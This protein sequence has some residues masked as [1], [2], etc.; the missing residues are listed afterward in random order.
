MIG[1]LRDRVLER[2]G[3]A[4]PPNPDLPGLRSVYAAW[5]ERVPFDN[6]RK[7]IALLTGGDSPLPGGD[8]SDFFA[9][10]LS[11]GCGGTCW[12][13]SNALFE[14]LDSLGFRARRV[15]GSM[16]DLGSV[17]HA[18]VKVSLEGRDWLVDSS[19]LTNIP[20]PLACGVFVSDDPV[21][22]AEVE[23]D[24]GTHVIWIQALS[25]QSYLPCRLLV[26]PADH[27]FYSSCYEASRRRSPFN[28][29]L[30]VRCN[31]PNTVLLLMGA[32]LWTKTPDATAECELAPEGICRSL[33]DRFGIAE[34]LVGEF[35][36]IGALDASLSEAAGP[37]P[38][39]S[40]S[41]PPSMR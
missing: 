16:R 10:W 26:D 17:T 39:E 19:L 9:A 15:A 18:S 33:V 24:D 21:V 36:R 25:S 32:T 23:A 29:R 31:R 1:D 28:R 4:A 2:L 13:T 7:M 3:F 11:H 22:P 41:K 12:A 30:Y 5:C 14:L 37:K 40:P 27:A 8:A 34:A 20:L 6:L 38:P 35:A